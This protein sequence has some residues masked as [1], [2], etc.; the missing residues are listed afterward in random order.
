MIRHCVSCHLPS[1]NTAAL[2]S[3]PAYVAVPLYW[4]LQELLVANPEYHALVKEMSKY[5]LDYVPI[6]VNHKEDAS[7]NTTVPRREFLAASTSLA[8]TE[9]F[10]KQKVGVSAQQ[11]VKITYSLAATPDE[12]GLFGKEC[13]LNEQTLKEHP[14][15]YLVGYANGWFVSEL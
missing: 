6:H 5:R 2:C 10:L 3:T 14:M 12:V 15:P 13:E 4:C 7:R 11:K 9:D 1:C 8:A